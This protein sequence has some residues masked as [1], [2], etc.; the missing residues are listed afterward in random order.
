MMEHASYLQLPI[1]DPDTLCETVS[2]HIGSALYS[3]GEIDALVGTG[4]SGA[5]AVPLIAHALGKRMCVVR[6]ED[7]VG[8]HSCSRFEGNMQAGD[9]W[10]FVD[11]L[12]DSGASFVRVHTAIRKRYRGQFEFAGVSLYC[13]GI[14]FSASHH[15][16]D[17]YLRRHGGIR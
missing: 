9:R 7:D 3:I 2:D 14:A 4:L 1:H 16:I 15:I 12:I 10:L 17:D 13:S 8:T 5:M 6:K 11:D